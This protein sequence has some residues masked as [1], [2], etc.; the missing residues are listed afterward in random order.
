MTSANA[1]DVLAAVSFHRCDAA[2]SFYALYG[3][4]FCTARVTVIFAFGTVRTSYTDSAIN[5]FRDR[6]LL[7]YGRRINSVTVVANTRRT[8]PLPTAYTCRQAA[9]GFSI[10]GTVVYDTGTIYAMWNPSSAMFTEPNPGVIVLDNRGVV[11]FKSGTSYRVEEVR[12]AIDSAL[13]R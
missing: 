11:L 8:S 13:S 12:A 3:L 7:D 1:G 9:N 4:D 10:P 6:V 2:G 5:E